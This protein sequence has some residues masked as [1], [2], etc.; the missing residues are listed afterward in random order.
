[1]E[2]APPNEIEMLAS[3]MEEYAQSQTAMMTRLEQAVS[4]Q[5]SASQALTAQAVATETKLD[6]G[7]AR[8]QEAIRELTTGIQEVSKR[9]EEARQAVEQRIA[10]SENKMAEALTAVSQVMLNIQ[11]GQAQATPVDQ[12]RAEPPL[13]TA[14]GQGAT[15]PATSGQQA[16]AAPIN[17]T[18]AFGSGPPTAAGG[19]QV[20]GTPE[21]VTSGPVPP[22]LPQ[23][24]TPDGWAQ[25]HAQGAAQG[26]VGLRSKDFVHIE[27]FDG[28]LT[29]FPDWADRMAAKF[30]RA[31]PRLA[32]M[33]EWAEQQQQR[34]TEEMERAVDEPGLHTTR[35]SEAVYDI[36]ME[37]TTV[38]LYDKRRNAGQGRGLE[39]WRVLK[40]DFGMA[41]TDAQ[42][43]KLQMYMEPSRC[44]TVA[45]L[46]PALDKWEALGREITR[47]VD[48]DFRLLALRKMVP[49]Q[50][51]ESMTA[52]ASLRSFQDAL[53]FVRRQTTE[54]RNTAQVQEMHRQ[55]RQAP[56]PMDLGSAL[57]AAIAQL[58]DS[59]ASPTPAATTSAASL[60]GSEQQDFDENNPLDI[61]LHAL[62][63]KGKGKGKGKAGGGGPETRECWNCGRT[64]HLARDCWHPKK[65]S[66]P[67]GKGKG[68]DVGA[69]EESQQEASS[70]G[71][72]T[73]TL[74]CLLLSEQG[75]RC[76]LGACT[77]SPNRQ[78]NGHVAT[79]V[80]IDSGAAECVCGPEHFENF[81]VVTN[82]GSAKARMEYVCADGGRIP[83]LGAKE[84]K[85]IMNDGEKL[86]VKFQVTK[87]DRPL[88]A[89]SKIV[90]A[91]HHVTFNDK[92]GSITHGTTGHK[93]MFAKQNGVY[94]LDL[95]VPLAHSS[96]GKR[97]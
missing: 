18:A 23:P 16:A 11:A 60:A 28:G 34:I 84:V 14:R 33:L 66:T 87:V 21:A 92:G 67:K 56:V 46:G 35:I 96:G 62:K 68:K 80:T 26:E 43:A 4:A 5:A 39:F 37:R 59:S 24:L 52:Q 2:A 3:R 74:G 70:S 73:I 86:N 94:V 30:R 93:T 27:K 83:N 97:Q 89:V 49:K 45:E 81:P 54:Y 13:P 20:G 1:M 40:R 50:V 82:E 55:G 77:T 6:A 31:H 79:Q 29:S 72:N 22:A 58:K 36:L 71:D 76:P 63:G 19:A 15:G 38:A 7:D 47:P 53:M 17:P 65:E 42:L 90:E 51:A 48:D 8:F 95:W 88:L 32:A 75:S 9:A 78:W 12:P 41:S 69:I 61:L 57:V 64:G 10:T 25:W 85:S 44:A 91:G